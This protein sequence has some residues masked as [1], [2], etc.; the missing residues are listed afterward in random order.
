MWL[1]FVIRGMTSEEVQELDMIAQKNN[2]SREQLV[3]DI[4]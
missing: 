3:T 1:M 2:M 4:S